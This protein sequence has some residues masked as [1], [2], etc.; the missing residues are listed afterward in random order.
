MH[1]VKAL[2]VFAL[3]VYSALYLVS[4]VRDPGAADG[5]YAFLYAR[6]LAFDGDLDF[7]NDYALCGDPYAQGVDR[8][9][10]RVDNPAYAG[11]ALVWTPL[12]LAA[13]VF[14]PVAKDAPL[15]VRAGCRGPIARFAL[16]SA[17]PLAALSIAL[18]FSVAR[19]WASVG[20]SFVA[21]VLFATASS[22]PQYASVFVSNSHAFECFFAAAV[23]WASFWAGDGEALGRWW[24]VALALAALTLQ[25]MPDAAYACIP[26][27]VIL[28]G[29]A[30]PARKLAVAAVVASG[31]L[32]GIGATLLLYRYLYGSP[33][34]LPQGRHFVHLAHAHPWLLLFAP[35]GGL[36]FATP[37]AYLAL[38]GIALG[39]REP[40]HRPFALAGALVVAACLFVASSPLDWHA[41]A[42]F[43]ARRLVVL[44]PL[45]VVFGALAL[46]A[47]AARVPS[48][49]RAALP[50]TGV[51]AVLVFGVPVLFAVAGTTQGKTPLDAAPLRVATAG[52]AY[53]AVAAI[54]DV[55]V[56]PAKVVYA[57]RFGMP[58]ASFG[59][60]TTDLHYR[61]SYRDLTWEPN[62]LSFTHPSLVA[63]SR[64]TAARSDGLLLV[65]PEAAVVWTAGW[66][67]ADRATLAL[68]ADGEGS[69]RVSLGSFFG[70]CDLGER[71]F[72]VGKSVVAFALP[73]GCFDS[74]LVE[75]GFRADPRAAVTLERMTLDDSRA[76]PPPF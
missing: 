28:S 35:Q 57:T 60:A 6:S 29:F 38:F 23:L 75:L 56:L 19:R 50:V 17:L 52:A 76:L 16:A 41:K 68:R 62:T 71:P 64:G 36:L 18:A 7:R 33:F 14:V 27:V 45:F 9:V 70:R 30:P 1:R 39:L 24:V 34:V 49:L 59:L 32:L 31:A 26:L 5:H 51:G 58:M 73:P 55:A 40:R 66:P 74:G 8:G 65:A 22:L 11:P 37:V 46:D 13:R 48:T 47:L 53:R 25:R 67:F 20:A 21:A 15:A 61:R 44:V 10:G 43:G 63:A 69:L 2:F 42:T 4:G 12:L 54:G 72:A 3:V